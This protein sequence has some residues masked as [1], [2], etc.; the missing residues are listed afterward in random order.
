MNDHRSSRGLTPE[1]ALIGAGYWGRN[2]ARN[3]YALGA[4]RTLCDTS[5]STLDS[6]GADYGTVQRV[7]EFRDVLADKAVRQVAI[8]APAA[9]HYEL[10]KA[11]L[12]A[13]KDV[14][15]EK[16]ICLDLEEARSL[17]KLAA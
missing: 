2:L 14:F 16:P 10:A 3:F 11:A 7:T 15:V 13:G 12:D 6:Y 1:L 17:V 5:Q 9:V 8:A 4:L